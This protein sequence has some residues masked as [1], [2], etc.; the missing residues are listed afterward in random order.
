M[1]ADPGQPAYQVSWI[2]ARVAPCPARVH[3]AGAA[4]LHPRR[5]G[6]GVSNPAFPGPP[7]LVEHALAAETAV[8]QTGAGKRGPMPGPLTAEGN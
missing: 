1:L 7:G 8:T 2:P 4:K 5:P 6:T 3:V